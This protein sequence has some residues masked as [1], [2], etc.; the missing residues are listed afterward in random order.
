MDRILLE[1]NDIAWMV[2]DYLNE[3]PRAIT[4]GL[5]REVDPAGRLPRERAYA[6]MLAALC[7]AEGD[8]QMW[9][10]MNMVREYRATDYLSD[11]YFS[12]VKFPETTVGSWQLTTDSYAAYEA[13]PCG[14]IVLHGDGRE[15]PQIGYFTEPFTF[16]VILE[17]GREWMAL[18]PNEIETM[19][20]PLAEAC[21]RVA[22][23]GLGLGYFAY[24]ASLKEEVT[25]VTVVERSQDVIDLFERYLLPQFPKAGK[26]GIVRSDAFDW[27]E[28]G[29][30]AQGYD[31]AFF[32]LWHD[33]GD[34][35]DLYLRCRSYQPRYPSVRFLYW[36]EGFMKSALRWRE[37]Q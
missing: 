17:D 10:F 5:L 21:G 35:P 18:K 15:V 30:L 7:G 14:D 31:S 29:G 37:G 23:F 2:S 36:I 6:A 13:F 3:T 24:M 33:N 20:A 19:K 27:L 32:D 22:V 1:N 4:E 8:S 9:Y 16:P 28:C 12:G 26:I 11:Q 25:A 34:G